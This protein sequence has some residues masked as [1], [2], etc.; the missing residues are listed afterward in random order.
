MLLS[1][2]FTR[3]RDVIHKEG[4]A[5]GSKIRAPAVTLFQNP[6]DPRRRPRAPADGFGRMDLFFFL[7]FW[8]IARYWGVN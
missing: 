3:P 2:R 5:E 8:T 6:G 1:D 4:N 7:F